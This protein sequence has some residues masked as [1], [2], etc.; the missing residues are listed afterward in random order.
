MF[1]VLRYFILSL[2]VQLWRWNL[3]NILF[4]VFV[5][6]SLNSWGDNASADE[7]HWYLTFYVALFLI[8]SIWEQVSNSLFI[9]NLK[10]CLELYGLLPMLI[11]F[12]DKTSNIFWHKYLGMQHKADRG[13]C[14]RYRSRDT[15][16]MHLRIGMK[17]VFLTCSF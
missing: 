9:K 15:K 10:R 3:R 17:G 13:R 11:I 5:R 6:S 1:Y 16:F 4:V 12:T 7:E 2:W 8:H 14:Y